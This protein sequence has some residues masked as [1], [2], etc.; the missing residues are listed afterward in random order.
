MAQSIQSIHPELIHLISAGEVIDSLAAVVRELIDNALDAGADRLN[1]VIWPD[2]W[3]LRLSDNGS[4][5]AQADLDNAA[6]AHSTSKLQGGLDSIS[7]LGFRGE[8]LHSVARLGHLTIR[9]RIAQSDEGWEVTYGSSGEVLEVSPTAIAPGTVV[10]VTD[11]F[12]DWRFRRQT[13]TPINQQLK[14]VQTLIYNYALCHPQVTW[15]VWQG[16]RLWFHLPP[17]ESPQEL[18]PLLLPSI[19]PSVLRSRRIQLPQLDLEEGNEALSFH[20]ELELVLGLPDRCHRHRPDW[21]RI[22]VNGRCV[23]VHGA[24]QSGALLQPLEQSILRA[25]RQ[26]LPRHRYPL[27]FAHFRLDPRYIDWNRH[28]AKSEIYIRDLD[29]WRSHLQSAIQDLL[30]FEE[31]GLYQSGQQAVEQLLLTAEMPGSYGESTSASQSKSPLEA[32]AAN[33][34]LSVSLSDSLPQP[35]MG[36]MPLKAIAQLHRTYILCEYESGIGLVEQHVAHERVLYDALEKSWEFVPL[37]P[38]QRLKGLTPKQVDNL[39]TIGIEIEPFGPGVWLVRSLPKI[40]LDDPE[41][42]EGLRILSQTDRMTDAMASVAC[43]SAIN[44]GTE[45]S[46]PQMQNLINAWQQTQTP[47]TCPHG[48]PIYLSLEEKD[49]ARFFRRNWTISNRDEPR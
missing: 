28:P 30:S 44:N 33:Q 2:D 14:G 36:L 13:L 4:G 12:A 8:A 16:D 27:C 17:G 15:Q 24:L 35:Q 32:L 10:K 39:E 38:P 42:V 18:V 22:A 26:T 48:R 21:L 41:P 6:L 11:L 7:T 43:R 1:L 25:F 20:N 40:M 9:S 3:S 49:L 37:D 23:Q 34:L 19:D 47:R 31:S 29:H 45:L 46:L 5:L